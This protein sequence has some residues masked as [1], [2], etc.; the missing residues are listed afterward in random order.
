MCVELCLG[1]SCLKT[2]VVCR[3]S[4]FPSLKNSL[5]RSPWCPRQRHLQ[6][7]FHNIR[8]VDWGKRTGRPL[9]MICFPLASYDDLLSVANLQGIN[10]GDLVFIAQLIKQ[11]MFNFESNCLVNLVKMSSLNYNS[12]WE[13]TQKSSVVGQVISTSVQSR[14]RHLAWYV[15]FLFVESGTLQLIAEYVGKS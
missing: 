2:S 1:G 10:F 5:Q 7:L 9:L 3:V 13:W 15:L 4:T 8:D 12:A 14:V 6:N 11:M